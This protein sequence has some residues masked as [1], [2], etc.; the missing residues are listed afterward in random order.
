MPR[1]T[2]IRFWDRLHLVVGRGGR[3]KWVQWSVEG[4][5]GEKWVWSKI[6]QKL[7]KGVEKVGN[8]PKWGS[9]IIFLDSIYNFLSNDV[10]YGLRDPL[11]AA[12]E[13]LE[14]RKISRKSVEN[15]TFGVP[16]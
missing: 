2:S 5:L 12:I 3:A 13:F 9:F 15:P 16:W 1:A 11:V 7:I 8:R 4:V 10:Y 14:N 6:A